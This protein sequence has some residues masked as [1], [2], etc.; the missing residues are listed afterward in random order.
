[1]AY[2]ATVT[3]TAITGPHG[4]RY[5]QV[6][7]SEVEAIATSQTTLSDTT[8][9]RP[10]PRALRLLRQSCALTGGD[11]AGTTVDPVL[12]AITDP[13][14]RVD[15][16]VAQND[17]AAS[18]VNNVPPVPVPVYTSDGLLYHRSVVDSGTDSDIRTEYLFEV[19]GR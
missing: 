7:I 1:M 10:L 17:V 8:S 15:L 3:H 18:K 14:S 19:I 2:T 16:I 11:D 9:S 6:V 4:Q 13:A 12:G 5:L